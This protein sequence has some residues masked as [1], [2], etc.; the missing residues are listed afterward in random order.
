MQFGNKY[1][2]ESRATCR[3]APVYG[4]FAARHANSATGQVY[5]S[6]WGTGNL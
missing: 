2:W 3:I 4:Q 1:L 5:V 6:E